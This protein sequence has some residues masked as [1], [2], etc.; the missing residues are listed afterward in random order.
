MTQYVLINTFG[1]RESLVP[2]GHNEL[3][4][5]QRQLTGVTP[6]PVLVELDHFPGDKHSYRIGGNNNGRSYYTA[7][8]TINRCVISAHDLHKTT[9]AMNRRPKQVALFW[10]VLSAL[11][12]VCVKHNIQLQSTKLEGTF[13]LYPQ[14]GSTRLSIAISV[15]WLVGTLGIVDRSSATTSLLDK[16]LGTLQH[17]ATPDELVTALD[18][19]L[20]ESEE[21]KRC[22]SANPFYRV[23]E[24]LDE[25]GILGAAKCK[26]IE[27]LSDLIDLHKALLPGGNEY[28]D[29]RTS[30]TEAEKTRDIEPV[31]TDTLFETVIQ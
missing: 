8:V 21:V 11:Y 5:I 26:T 29:A 10:E 3:G 1:E 14:F 4:W 31:R 6:R 18:K 23:R 24:S 16:V 19:M 25:M 15:G 9:K 22:M 13:M 27:E 30:Y 20:D 28:T 7:R 2:S 12:P 17:V